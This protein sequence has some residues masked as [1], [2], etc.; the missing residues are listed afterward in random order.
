VIA[1]RE[2]AGGE[3]T[4]PTA[5]RLVR[6]GRKSLRAQVVSQA[7]TLEEHSSASRSIAGQR[8]SL[9]ALLP[10]CYR[11]GV[12]LDGEG[13]DY[14]AASNPGPA[15][16]HKYC[17][18]RH[19]VLAHKIPAHTTEIGGP[20][21]TTSTQKRQPAA[22]KD[23]PRCERCGCTIA[24]AGYRRCNACLGK[25]LRSDTWKRREYYQDPAE[26]DASA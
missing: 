11:A 23:R 12:E 24:K 21:T 22:P 9:G 17:A 4:D 14:S 18:L 16:G 5:V 26:L 13:A 2:R 6:Q 20:V 8:A 7:H 1:T 10:G 3:G 25:A 15:L 19:E